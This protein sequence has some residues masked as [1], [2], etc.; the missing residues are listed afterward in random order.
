MDIGD[1]S[2]NPKVDIAEVDQF[3][4]VDLNDA[5]RNG[6]VRGDLSVVDEDYNDIEDPR[7]VGAKPRD[8]FE[9]IEM[10]RAAL[11]AGRVQ[12]D[13]PSD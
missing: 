5:F 10:G 12:S 6:V 3:G 2:F 11:R 1:I 4:Y 8:S 13:Q 9:A 7:L